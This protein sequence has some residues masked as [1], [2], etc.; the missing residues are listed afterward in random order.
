MVTYKYI[1]ITCVESLLLGGDSMNKKLFKPGQKIP[2][3][4][5]AEVI[6]QIG[7]PT[8]NEV[9]I[10]EGKTFPPTPKKGQKYHI[11][12]RTKHKNT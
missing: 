8:G 12:D 2:E 9:T 10:I 1:S 11:V 5:Q 7:N 3:S 4:G 6:N